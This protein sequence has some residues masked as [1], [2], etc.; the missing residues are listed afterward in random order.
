MKPI[1]LIISFF[2][3]VFPLTSLAKPTAQGAKMPPAIVSVIKVQ[4]QGWQEQVHST[5]T[6]TADQGIMVKAEV[7]GRVTRVYFKSGQLVKQGDPLVELDQSILRAQLQNFQAQLRLNELQYKRYS[8]LYKKH[9]VS[10]SEYDTAAANLQSTQAQ[11]AQVQ[12]QLNQML[13]KAPFSGKLGLA[14]VDLGDYVSAGQIIVN[15]QDT[16]PMRVDFS[17]PEVY[18]SKVA[19]GNT[20]LVHSNSSPGQTFKGNVYAFEASID[21]NTRT[22]AMRASVPNTDNKLIPGSF[23]DVTLLLGQAAKLLSL[24]QTA[25]ISSLEGDYVY[26]AINGRAV[27]TPVVVQKRSSQQA[28]I[29][30]GLTV[31]D[32]VITDGQLK[33]P[34]D[35]APIM[36]LPT[37]PSASPTKSPTH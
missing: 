4:E 14:Q 1:I 32:T 22:L 29:S 13:I 33:I 7:P 27:K 5:G 19:V 6:L 23:V 10:T 17:V 34:F 3:G 12:A 36:T 24:P 16:N 26:R 20:V 18:L 35:G 15:L 31:G 8:D 21:P 9:F 30:S 37:Q 28:I 2:C 11:V 25:L